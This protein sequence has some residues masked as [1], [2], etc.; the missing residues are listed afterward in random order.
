MMSIRDAGGLF[1]D[2]W[3]ETLRISSPIAINVLTSTK[4]QV[5]GG[6]YFVA[7]DQPVTVVLK[8]LH[9]DRKAWGDDIDIYRPERF[10]D[11]GFQNLKPHSWKPVSLRTH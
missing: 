4:D 9:N 8:Y 5:L 6:K 10:L 3:K 2:F 7:K 1:A 11:G